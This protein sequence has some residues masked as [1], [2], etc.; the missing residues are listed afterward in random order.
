MASNGKRNMNRR[1][2]SLAAGGA[3]LSALSPRLM[4]PAIAQQPVQTFS[5]ATV[6]AIAKDLA[7]TDFRRPPEVAEP[8]AGLGYDQYRDIKFRSERAFWLGEQRGFSLELLHAGFIY[9]TPVEIHIVEDGTAKPI[10]YDSELF[11]F[12]P[13]LTVPPTRDVPLFSGIRLRYPINT[14]DYLDEVAVF[15]GGR[16]ISA[17]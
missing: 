5:R 12:G 9:E 13:H 16:A 7:E 4:T 6:V 8:F 2:F 15:Q 10:P 11:D 17:R 1:E 14:P 3:A